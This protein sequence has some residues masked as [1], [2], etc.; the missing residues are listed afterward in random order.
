MRKYLAALFFLAAVL[1]PHLADAAAPSSANLSP[2]TGNI[3]FSSGGMSGQY[4]YFRDWTSTYNFPIDTILEHSS[5]LWWAETDPIAGDEPGVTSTWVQLSGGGSGSG[6]SIT[7]GTA[8]PTGGSAGDAYFQVNSSSEV[9]SLWRNA[10]GTW[11]EYILPAGGGV[12]LSDDSPQNVAAA[13]SSGTAGDASRSDHIHD[14]FSTATPSNL[15][16]TATAG[17][18]AFASRNDHVHRGLSDTDPVDIGTAAAGTRP[19]AS[20]D[21]HV[22]GGGGAANYRGNWVSTGVYAR[23]DEVHNSSV[24]WIRNTTTGGSGGTP[25]NTNNDWFRIV[26]VET[27]QATIT[28]S[29]LGGNEIGVPNNGIANAQ[30]SD[31]S[32]GLTE[33]RDDATELLC[34]D[35]SGG[36]AGQVCARNTAGDSYELIDQSAGG[37]GTDDQTADEVPVTVTN[38]NGNLGAADNDVQAAL[39][40][41]DDVDASDIPLVV[42][43]FDGN[44]GAADN[45]VQAAFETLDD[46]AISTAGT[47]DQTASEVPVTASGFDGNL[48][49]TDDTVQKVAQKFDDLVTSVTATSAIVYKAHLEDSTF[50]DAE[51][52]D[53][54]EVMEINIGS[55][56]IEFNDGPYTHTTHTDGHELVCVPDGQPGY[57]EVESDYSSQAKRFNSQS[58]NVRRSIY[59]PG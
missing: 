29:G 34:P 44:L 31:D 43:D 13:G 4:L 19:F 12:T 35:P 25:G 46:L 28:G 52:A 18:G 42:T 55:D 41:L 6:A 51:S 37:G 27:D 33:L 5:E 15:G 38:F 59:D 53:W 1:F 10:S 21:D 32:V 24:Y 48:A 7:A 3:R 50:T 11:T 58:S 54:H 8:D 47:D 39:E 57:Y 9:T 14:A 16:V 26:G 49:T 30:M 40:T 45:D 36:T 23:G 20:R 2:Y 22:H 56:D 17:I